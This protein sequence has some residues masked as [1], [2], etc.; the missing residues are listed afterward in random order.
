MVAEKAAS[1]SPEGRNVENVVID[2]NGEGSDSSDPE[3]W[4][5]SEDE[6]DESD[7]ESEEGDEEDDDSSSDEPEPRKMI[8]VVNQALQ[9]S[10]AEL[11]VEIGRVVAGLFDANVVV[12][13]ADK[14]GAQTQQ[15]SL[16]EDWGLWDHFGCK[17]ISL[18]AN[19]VDEVVAIRDRAREQGIATVVARTRPPSAAGGAGHGVPANAAE[20][21][22]SILGLGP[23]LDAALDPLTG[24]LKTLSDP[25]KTLKKQIA[26]ADQELA[27]LQK[28][29]RQ[30]AADI[31]KLEKERDLLIENHVVKRSAWGC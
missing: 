20:G 21:V 3:L 24:H 31:E 2:E 5:G 14:S 12:E 16:S 27:K 17:K 29:S 26:K 18:E 10:A 30:K 19:S 15:S 23:T 11:A 9:L 7:D 4:E 13:Q 1:M 25:T 6:E 8:L 28:Q 22:I